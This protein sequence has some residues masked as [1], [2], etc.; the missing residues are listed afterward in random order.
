MR[1]LRFAVAFGVAVAR[2]QISPPAPPHSPGHYDPPE[3]PSPPSPPPSAPPP[4]P[5]PKRR[6]VR[7][8]FS[9]GAISV[10]LLFGSGLM[11]VVYLRRGIVLAQESVVNIIKETPAPLDAAQATDDFGSPLPPLKP[12]PGGGPAARTMALPSAM[13]SVPLN[14]GAATS[15]W[16]DARN[17]RKQN[18][19][20]SLLG[21]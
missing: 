16:V 21:T 8:F 9:F 13:V 1:L 6:N 17:G 20:K 18:E 4:S 3:S 14:R 12:L 7:P 5:P 2:A 11:I 19:R 10:V 15:G